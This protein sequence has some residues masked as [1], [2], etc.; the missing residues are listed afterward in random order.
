MNSC[1]FSDDNR[2]N[3]I[4]RSGIHVMGSWPT[5]F[6]VLQPSK[7]SSMNRTA[8]VYQDNFS[9][10]RCSSLFVTKILIET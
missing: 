4:K 8:C 7:A 10:N 9:I 6:T 3:E 2:M 5:N 1:A